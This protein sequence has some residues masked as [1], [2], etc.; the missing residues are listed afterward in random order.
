[1]VIST[2]TG[3]C[4]M[5]IPHSGA[6]SL[7]RDFDN[8]A[9]TSEPISVPEDRPGRCKGLLDAAQIEACLHRSHHRGVMML[10]AHAAQLTIERRIDLRQKGKMHREFRCLALRR[11]HHS[12]RD[13]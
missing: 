1:A 5:A 7:N 8:A 13:E 12:R 3:S 10:D 6:T 2:T 9:A 11:K 4:S